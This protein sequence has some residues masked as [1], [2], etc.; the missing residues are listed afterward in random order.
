MMQGL[1]LSMRANITFIEEKFHEYNA[2]CFGGK[3]PKVPILL[4]QA[5]TYIGICTFK[6]N[7]SLFGKSRPYDFKLHFS[8]R[9]DLP[10]NV[11]EDTI[12]HEMIHLYIG[13][14]NIKDTSPHGKVFLSFMQQINE[15]FGRNI[16][17]SH[18]A[19]PE[20]RQS[21]VNT[22]VQYHVIAAVKYT[23][24]RTGVKVLPRIKQRIDDYY[25]VIIRVKEIAS[26]DFYMS[27]NPFFNRYPNSG[28]FKVYAIKPEEL[29]KHLADAELINYVCSAK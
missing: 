14:N 15:E 5:K 13:V 26:I 1:F 4:S 27:C 20:Q 7:T 21:A 16:T 25:R 10:Q 18:K 22:R 3:L 28:A 19:T 8:T 9:L 2:M 12:I 23:D 11:L 17:I 29:T 24:G 6:K